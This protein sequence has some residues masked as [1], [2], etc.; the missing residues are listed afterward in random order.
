MKVICKGVLET[1]KC[2]L[3]ERCPHGEKHTYYQERCHNCY[4]I[5]KLCE[6][7]PISLEYKMKEAIEKGER[8]NE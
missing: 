6:C 5:L 3:N 7:I 4:S 2:P 8:E 1:G